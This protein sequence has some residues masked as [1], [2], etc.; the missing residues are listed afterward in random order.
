MTNVY[1][2][3]LVQINSPENRSATSAQNLRST[4]HIRQELKK[5]LC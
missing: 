4:E 2:W 1:G 3:H 5:A